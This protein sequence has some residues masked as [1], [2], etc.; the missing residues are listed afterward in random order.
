MNLSESAENSS[1][2]ARKEKSLSVVCQNFIELFQNAPTYNGTDNSGAEVDICRVALQLDV[3]R[4]RIYDIINIMESLEIVRRMKKNTYE[5]HGLD[6]LPPF[7]ARLQKEGRQ[8][9]AEN[10]KSPGDE[11][12]SS[13]QGPAK[14][15]GMGKTCQKLIQIFLVTGKVEI[16]LTDAAEQVLGPLPKSS[17]QI[18]T[19]PDHALPA[20]D[21]KK[22]APASKTS[23]ATEA[24]A[25][26]TK[27]RR[28]YDIANVLQSIG[29]IQKE[30]VGSTSSQNKPSF[31]WVYHI[32][33]CDVARYLPAEH[34][35]P[36]RSQES[37]EGSRDSKSAPVTP[38]E[39]PSSLVVQITSSS[40]NSRSFPPV[41]VTQDECTKSFN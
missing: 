37:N 23:T 6:A 26:K 8:E 11:E 5:W 40:L 36:S 20:C 19:T 3:K 32:L 33:P 21:V 22:V 34:A 4:R 9:K 29:I 30:N 18:R 41:T 10:D 38:E 13:N 12:D 17:K 25:M 14:I 16:G 15:K 7:F 31:R 1:S 24:K 27:I 35:T 28:M 2:S 39:S